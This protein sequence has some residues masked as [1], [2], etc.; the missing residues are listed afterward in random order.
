MDESAKVEVQENDI[1]SDIGEDIRAI[2]KSKGVTLTEM[3]RELDRSVGYLSQVERGI[4]SVSTEDLGRI[5]HYFDVP[6]S[7][8][9]M[10]SEVPE[11]ERGYITRSKHRR[12][13]GVSEGGLAE[14]LL[15]PD[16]GGDYEVLR[17]VFAAGAKLGKPVLRETE[18]TA[19]ILS[20]KLDIRLGDRS[21]TVRAGDC[22]RFKH[23]TL[24]WENSYDEPAVA[25]WVIAPPI[26]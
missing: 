3:A 22:F 18:E 21:F 23:E 19:Y 1:S 15:S 26:Y 9:L 6:L 16:L 24:Y 4:S 14:E 17:S 5:A 11:N 12:V 10:K 20:G 25:I 2:R 7:W 13:S 8:F